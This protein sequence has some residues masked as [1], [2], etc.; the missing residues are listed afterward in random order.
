MYQ[1][2]LYNSQY[3][4]INCQIQSLPMLSW[5]VV[6]KLLW[7]I[8]PEVYEEMETLAEEYDW[9]FTYFLD[10]YSHLKDHSVVITDKDLNIQCASENVHKMTSYENYELIG[11]TPGILQGKDTDGASKKMI[12]KAIT[13]SLPFKARLVNYRKD[14][15]EYG[16]EI[17]AFPIFNGQKETTHFIAFENEY[18]V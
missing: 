16:C 14:G 1:M 7:D 3:A 15:T 12:R 6:H 2:D 5:D 10:S 13:D 8:H 9:H 18:F 11:H 4:I 17:H